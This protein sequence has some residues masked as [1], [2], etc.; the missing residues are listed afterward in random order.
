[1][2][3]GREEWR[4]IIG[5]GWKAVVEPEEETVSVFLK[6]LSAIFELLRADRWWDR[7][8]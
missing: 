2:T 6:I 7:H 5:Q 8:R 1:M 4:S 3:V